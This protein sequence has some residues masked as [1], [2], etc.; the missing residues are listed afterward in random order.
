MTGLLALCLLTADP[1][2]TEVRV[3]N[4]RAELTRG[5][6]AYFVRG[7]GGSEHLK[8]AA[9]RGANSI[10]TWGA[11]GAEA[12]LDEAEK[13]GLTVCVGLW[14]AHPGTYVDYADPAQV[15]AQLDRTL[16]DVRRLKD[17]P[18]LLMW[19]VGN[20]MEGDGTDPNVMGALE[21]AAAAIKSIDPKHPTMTAL[22]GTPK[23][24]IEGLNRY[25]PSIDVIGINSYG[26]APTAAARYAEN[27]GTRPFM[28]T[29]FGPLGPWE[30][31]STEWQRRIEE[32]STAKAD[33]YRAAY[34]GS[35][36]GQPLCVGSY[37][38][39]WGTK[40]ETT[41]TWFGMVLDD[42]SPTAAVD[43]MQELWTTQPPANLAPTIGVPTLPKV[44]GL[45]PGETLTA[46]VEA[47][48][49]E[50]R[51]L[52]YEW[53]LRSDGGVLTNGAVRQDPERD[54][55]DAITADGP[56]A[57][58]TVPKGGGGYRLFAYAFDPAG[59]AAVANRPIRVDAPPAAWSPRKPT[60]PLAVYEESVDGG[61]FAPAGYMGNTSAIVT[62]ETTHDPHSG[63]HCL[64]VRYTAAGEWG[65][66][67]WQAVPDDWDNAK[68]GGFD[69]SHA[70]EVEFFARGETGGERVTFLVGGDGGGRYGDT[71]KNELKDVVLTTDWQRLRVVLDG[72]DASRIRTGFGW[73]VAGQGRPVTFH[74]DDVRFVR[75]R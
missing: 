8:L 2:P 27:G 24:K 33:R 11:D 73:V 46:R 25:C 22:A 47:A 48:D 6:E 18:A 7:V 69:L 53:V 54:F 52:R 68:P 14:L 42:G 21:Q 67:L 66:V 4:G 36:E 74:L 63:D 13:N 29:E 64:R 28:L 75:R 55:P 60:L 34:E 72:R 51:P 57:T 44:D 71:G 16:A 39:L 37:A 40:Q 17:H 12:I 70:T 9:D 58:L 59:N 26:G 65:G 20:E 43:V 3:G 32:T 41:A 45:K 31:A 62:E 61:P 38:F 23:S 50:G 49:P 15:Q 56:T 19:G 30:V 5:G 1:I 35:V 10:R